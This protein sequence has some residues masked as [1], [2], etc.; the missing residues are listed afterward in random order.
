VPR[1]ITLEELADDL[2]VSHQAL[3]EQLRRGTGGLMEDT[4]LAG[5]SHEPRGGRPDSLELPSNRP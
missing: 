4:L 1:S 2:S 5:T 3:S